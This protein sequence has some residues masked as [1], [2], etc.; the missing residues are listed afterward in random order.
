MAGASEQDV[1]PIHDRVS[2]WNKHQ[3]LNF[4]RLSWWKSMD[5]TMSAWQ[6]LDTSPITDGMHNP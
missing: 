6:H 5:G 4:G 1:M 2:L 3:E